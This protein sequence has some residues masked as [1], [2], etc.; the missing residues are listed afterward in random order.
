MNAFI[1]G[2]RES[3]VMGRTCARGS[4]EKNLFHSYSRIDTPNRS[5]L[6]HLQ[7]NKSSQLIESACLD[8]S[9]VVVEEQP[10]RAVQK[11]EKSDVHQNATRE[12]SSI[13]MRA[14]PSR[15][16]MS[17]ASSRHPLRFRT[18]YDWTDLIFRQPLR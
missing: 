10:V 11:D 18:I 17:P 5:S 12:D 14:T 6:A 8:S 4:R 15:Y 1:H 7:V 9:D 13:D 3:A 16:G 2:R